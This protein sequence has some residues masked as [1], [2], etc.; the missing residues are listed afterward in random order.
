MKVILIMLV[1]MPPMPPI[2]AMMATEIELVY[3]EPV[4]PRE[5]WLEPE[6]LLVGENSDGSVVV[7]DNPKYK[8]SKDPPLP[9]RR[10]LMEPNEREG[11]ILP[12][13]EE[14]LRGEQWIKPESQ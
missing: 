13:K 8:G 5:V 6:F 2:P 12:M 14:D 1:W 10:D 7:R 9:S 11:I 3:Q 4:Q